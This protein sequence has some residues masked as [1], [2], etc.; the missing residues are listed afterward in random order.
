M[1]GRSLH[2]V[3]HNVFV[4]ISSVPACICKSACLLLQLL[5]MADCK[6]F[7]TFLK[8]PRAKG[9]KHASKL[10]K[11][12]AGDEVWQTA[13]WTLDFFSLYVLYLWYTDKKEREIFLLYKKIQIGSVPNI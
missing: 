13:V 10:M 6:N 7:I 9:L 1:Q 8:E 2:P 5:N 4:Q 3:I 12:S 11:E